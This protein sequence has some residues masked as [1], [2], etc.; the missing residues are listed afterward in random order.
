MAESEATSAGGSPTRDELKLAL[1]AFNKRLRLTRLDDE[2]KLGHGA[3]T[4]GGK[5]GIVAITPPN[6]FPKTIWD[7]LV[8]QGKLKYVG[9]G[10][11]EPVIP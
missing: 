5:S 3:M 1:K 6:Q 4:A 10:L 8:K 2:S 11:Y 9:H 7:E